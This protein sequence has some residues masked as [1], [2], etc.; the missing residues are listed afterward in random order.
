MEKEEENRKIPNVAF[1][2]SPSQTKEKR[3][4]ARQ[5]MQ[6]WVSLKYEKALCSL[7]LLSI[8]CSFKLCGPWAVS[9]YFLQVTSARKL[10]LFPSHIF[11]PLFACLPFCSQH[12]KANI[13]NKALGASHICCWMNKANATKPINHA[14]RYKTTVLFGQRKETASPSLQPLIW[15]DTWQEIPLLSEA[16]IKAKG[17]EQLGDEITHWSDLANHILCSSCFLGIWNSSSHSL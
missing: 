7:L 5:K 11:R 15:T 17:W 8:S 1:S 9:C 12:G 3:D 13:W 14:S 4:F 16:L 6:N 10:I 2:L